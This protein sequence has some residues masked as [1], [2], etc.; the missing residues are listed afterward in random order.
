MVLPADV[1]FF[2]SLSM[3]VIFAWLSWFA[4]SEPLAYM[5]WLSPVYL[6]TRTLW[7]KNPGRYD[8]IISFSFGSVYLV[9]TIFFSFVLG[10]WITTALFR[11]WHSPFASLVFP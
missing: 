6:L 2:C 10:G 5:R 8:R 9:M 1:L 3:M 11:L 7:R 4:F